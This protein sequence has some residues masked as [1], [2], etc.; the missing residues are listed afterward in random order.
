MACFFYKYRR[1]Y[2][3]I[4]LVL[5]L[6]FFP[7]E[8]NLRK[9][10]IKFAL[11]PKKELPLQSEIMKRH[12]LYLFLAAI[13]LS[14]TAC[15][16]EMMQ[17][18]KWAK[19]GNPDQKDSAAMFFM[20][21]KDYE[22]AS[23]LFEEVMG[24]KRNSTRYEGLLREYAQ[25]KFKM[26]EY[27][28]A[29]YYYDQYLRQ[30]PNGKG[31]EDAGF[32]EAYAFYLQSDPSYLD[33][34]YTNKAMQALQLF[35]DQHPNSGRRK[36]AEKYLIELRERKATKAFNQAKL[37]YKISD[38]KAAVSYLQTFMDDFPDSRYRE[39]AQFL[40]VKSAVA[41]AAVSIDNKKINRYKD[42]LEFY[43]KFLAKYPTSTYLK[44]AQNL[45]EKSRNALL[46]LE[47]NNS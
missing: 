42:A 35:L 28:T 33:Q 19:K 3:T 23:I 5:Y 20:R 37:Y 12:I 26:Q 2:G 46:K 8:K 25:C 31:K 21:H 43:Q 29:S 30:Y 6:S 45:Y 32:M 11:T 15:S 17:M 39:E 18:N 14:F 10:V 24:L 4:K 9:S 1:P 7:C 36:E 44:D 38:F 27:V 47:K 22:K 40:L 13:C 34:S 16:K 41:L